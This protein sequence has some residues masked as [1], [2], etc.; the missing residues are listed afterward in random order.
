VLW[1]D[2]D[3]TR[4]VAST[5]HVNIRSLTVELLAQ[6]LDQFTARRNARVKELKASGQADLASELAALKKPAVHLWAADQVRDRALLGGLRRAAQSVSRA[7]AAAATGRVNAAHD[8]RA[9][10]EEFQ[11]NVESVAT[12][13]ASVLR[14]GQHSVGE[15]TLRRIREIFR[16][17]ALQ[18]G[19]TWD[20]LQEGGLTA[21]PRPG[22]DML[23]MFAAG[24]T[25]G[26]GKR[27][28]QADARRA[29]ELAERAAR[30]DAERAQQAV[31]AA[32]RRRQEAKEAAVAA[33]LAG[34]RAAAAEKEA[35]RARAQ[36]KKSQRR[37]GR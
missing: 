29:A 28:E 4:H 22:D 31:A 14:H 17:A 30:A 27:A 26:T 10:S 37:S 36:A 20:R 25:P 21:E 6:P 18:G 34:E 9:T 11:R 13:A 2:L 12:A 5:H 33:R 16:L 15:E 32:E 7:Q 35:A 24:A 8:L 19:E 23:A 1:H 3:A